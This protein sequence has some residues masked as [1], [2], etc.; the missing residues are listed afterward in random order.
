MT[1]A[2]RFGPPI[3]PRIPPPR[4]PGFADPGATVRIE[5]EGLS[6]QIRRHLQAKELGLEQ[7]LD[8][9][10]DEFLKTGLEQQVRKAVAAEL[11]EII[12]SLV[13]R[14]LWDAEHEQGLQEFIGK[15]IREALAK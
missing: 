8:R 1:P 15:K 11:P 3:D 12:D 6:L 7:M 5:V 10:V 4:A 13:R 14:A 2:D 9:A